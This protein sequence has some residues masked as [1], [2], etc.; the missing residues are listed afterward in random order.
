MSEEMDGLI[1]FYASHHAMRAEKVL[2]EAGFLVALI[3]GPRELS[4]N[5]GVA[6]RFEYTRSETALAILAGKKVQIDA[7]HEYHPRV[8]TWTENAPAANG[9]KRRLGLGGLFKR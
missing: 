1:S 4:P 3:P 8:A 2:G 7:I 6:L 9:V 5:C